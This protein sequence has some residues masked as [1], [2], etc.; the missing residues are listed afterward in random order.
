MVE[1]CSGGWSRRAGVGGVD[2]T[3]LPDRQGVS[4]VTGSKAQKRSLAEIPAWQLSDSPP[5]KATFTTNR[6]YDTRSKQH[7]E[8]GGSFLL[9]PSQVKLQQAEMCVHCVKSKNG[10]S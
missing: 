7:I 8:A 2:A 9:S 4:S 3:T 10:I 1:Q 5:G 6:F